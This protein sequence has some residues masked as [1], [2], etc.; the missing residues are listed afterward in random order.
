[1]GKRVF[2]I[3][4]DSFGI[5]EAPDA[6]DFRDVGA[7]TLR[8]CLTSAAFDCP[9]MARL[10]LFDIE[11]AA[12]PPAGAA[13][14][15]EAL[16]A[17]A[18]GRGALASR[19]RLHELS[20]GKDT[21]IGHWELAG[22]VSPRPMPV[23]PNGF[24]ADFIH[25]FEEATGRKCIVNLPYSGT[26]VIREYGEEQHRTGALIVYTSA[27][28]VFQIAAN[29]ADVPI[30]ELYRY[31]QIARDMLRGDLAVGRVIARPYVG[32][33]AENFTRTSRR[34]D[35]ALSPFA[36]TMLD[37]LKEA[38]KDVLGIGKIGD[39][40]NQQGLTESTRTS[41][42]ADGCEKTLE[43]AERDF[44]GLCFVNLVDFDMLYGHRRDVDGYANAL[45]QFDRFLD[46]FLPVLTPDDLLMLTADHGC[47]PA[48][49]L[50]TDHTREYVPL[51]MYSP[52]MEAVDYGTVDGFTFA[53][54]KTLEFLGVDDPLAYGK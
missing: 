1:M 37:V 34:H 3:V 28:S 47:D 52:G 41:G 43:T 4:L 15:E 27:D 13:Y 24:P 23:F 48:F 19:A 18:E 53:A 26:D 6:A 49:T 50:S 51:L 33:S 46:R 31:C 44:D 21:I 42:N 7:N 16:R 11:G 40:F 32:D 14:M 12:Q 2:L 30:E 29:E 54:K 17:K 25:A 8:S 20:R 22:L 9:N 10:G 5:G 45:T 39:I 35:Y 36:P 38:G